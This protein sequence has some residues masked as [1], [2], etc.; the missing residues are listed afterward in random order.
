[1]FVK[2]LLTIE[3]VNLPILETSDLPVPVIGKNIYE[4]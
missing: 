1:M 4:G 2:K 3:L